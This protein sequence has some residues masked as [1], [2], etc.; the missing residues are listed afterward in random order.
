[1]EIVTFVRKFGNSMV[2]WG[3]GDENLCQCGEPQTAYHIVSDC[4]STEPPCNLTDVDNFVL[5]RYL[6]NCN[7]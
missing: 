4:K 6:M 1:M 5:K 3:F 2:K 7:F